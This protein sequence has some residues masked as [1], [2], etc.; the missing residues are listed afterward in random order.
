MEDGL[1]QGLQDGKLDHQAGLP[2]LIA[3]DARQLHRVAHPQALDVQGSVA[4]DGDAVSIVGGGQDHALR[5][6]PEHPRR[7][8]AFRPAV[9]ELAAPAGGHLPHRGDGLGV[10]VDG[11]RLHVDVDPD[12]LPVLA[13][14][15]PDHACV[16]AAV[17]ALGLLDEERAVLVD[18]V[19]VG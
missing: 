12:G 10:A 1:L 19:L 9:D 13:G 6:G 11:G 3:P 17:R 15:V 4:M 14:A 8:H 2:A 18:L 5:E 16:V 7:G